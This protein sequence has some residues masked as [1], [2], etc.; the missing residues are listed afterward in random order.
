MRIVK[1]FLM[2]VVGLLVVALQATA[3]QS[4]T[5]IFI[6][7]SAINARL[8]PL[9]IAKEQ[10]FFSKYGVDA[11]I[12]LVTSGPTVTAG[13]I[14]ESIHVGFGGGSAVL[15]AALAGVDLKVLGTFSH[16]VVDD[17]VVRP[18][19]KTPQ[20]LRGKRFGVTSIGG[21]GWMA[22]M[23]GLEQLGLDQQ[24]DNIRILP[25][26]GQTGRVQAMEAGTLDATTLDAVFSRRL[27]ERGFTILEEFHRFGIPIMLQGVVVTDAFQRKQTDVLEN[28][29]KAMVEG[30]V[31]VLSPR[32]RKTVLATLQRRLRIADPA[33][34]DTGYKDLIERRGLAP[35]P[36][37]T[38]DG[39]RNIQRLMK[40]H[41]PAIE[42]VDL[43][44]LIDARIMTKLD[45][46]GFIDKLYATYGGK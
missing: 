14:S 1:S 13:L 16:R 20:D 10:G 32:N 15:A 38:I 2:V 33:D 18:E 35:K 37:P 27:K 44:R 22:A 17:L 9:W 31:Y 8:V 39:L 5:K 41:N 34:L 26:G 23:L 46:S 28:V 4:S 29:L 21:A 3:A 7:H 45:Q 25:A 11:E 30:Q 42:K 24:K 12:L 19:I 40:V 6:S 43:E 36:Y